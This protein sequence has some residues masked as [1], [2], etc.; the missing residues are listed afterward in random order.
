MKTA[1]LPRIAIAAAGALALA[2]CD[3][4]GLT[5]NDVQTAAKERVREQLN[6][7]ADST[8]FTE[9]F[10]GQP[11][12]GDTVVCGTV[13]GRTAEGAEI[14]PRRF[15]A[16]A[17]PG[18]WV[19]FEPVTNVALPTKPDMFVDWYKACEPQAG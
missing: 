16:A 19:K 2:A 11:V 1:I 6:L 15:I 4:G 12:N 14:T 18:R 3:G 13:S 17:D 10:V 9:T 8:L 5:S 7:T